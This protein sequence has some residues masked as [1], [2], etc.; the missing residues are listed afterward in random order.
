MA[1]GFESVITE[2]AD[3]IDIK[4]VIGKG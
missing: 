3:A 4:T 2:E 1:A